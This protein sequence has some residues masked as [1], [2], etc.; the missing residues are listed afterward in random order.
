MPAH[1]LIAPPSPV[2]YPAPFWFL[3]FFKVFGFT[4]HV[5]PMNLWYAGAILA[6]VLSTLG[7]DNARIIGHHIARMLPFALAFGINFGVIPLL[8]V[9]VAYHR[10]FYPATILM[11]WPWFSVFWL[12]MVAYFALYMHRLTIE[13]YKYPKIGKASGWLAGGIFLLVGFFF[14]NALSL[15]TSVDRWWGIFKRANVAGAATGLALNAG[16]PTL[17]PRWL[18]MF[19]LAITTTAAYIVVDGAYL[20]GKESE[21]YRRYAGK[22]AAVLYTAG[23]LLYVAFGSWYIFGTRSFAFPLALKNPV[24]MVIFPLTAISPGLPLLLVVLQRNRPV[25]RL[26]ALT[27]LAQY[28]VIVLNAISRQWLQNVELAPYLDPAQ[29]PVNQQTSALIVFLIVFVLGLA[30]IAWMLSKI[31]GIAESPVPEVE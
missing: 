1:E 16:D 22:F 13:G 31:R 12:V 3:E 27:G 24:M 14:A 8:F 28:G 30:I 20:S 10:V 19:A 21:D 5:V 2:G 7:K 26:A 23:L 25:R 9:Q 4:L 18:F 17:I 15:T 11:A 29:H 6:A